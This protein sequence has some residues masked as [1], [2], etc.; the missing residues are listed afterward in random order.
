[1]RYFLLYLSTL[2]LLQ[3]GVSGTNIL[4]LGKSKSFMS[5][6]ILD[7]KRL[8]FSKLKEIKFAE[9]SDVA[10]DA[11]TQTLY[12]VSDKGLLYQ[13]NTHFSDKIDMLIP[14]SATKLKTKKGKRLKKWKRDS[15]GLTLDG[16]N[17]LLIS[18][19]G[20]A[21]ISWFHKNSAKVGRRIKNYPLPKLLT[22]EKNYRSRN[23]SLE[24]L[25]WHPRYGILTATE[26][27]LKKDDKKKQTI[28]A[29]SGK[30][31]HFKAEPEGRS[32]VSAIE[33]MDDGNILVLERSYTGLLEPF[34]VTLKKVYLSHCKNGMYQTKILAKMSNHKG[35]ELDNFEGLARVGKHRYVMVNDD[36]DNFFQRT[37]LIYFEVLDE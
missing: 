26:W 33:V 12:F 30:Q 19:E 1:M 32:G 29:L 10:Y 13:F 27:P 25:A 31:W 9:L 18:F 22:E 24:S 36:N 7:Q 3:A 4:P 21:K 16:H 5:I 17:R 6:K 11:N 28:Y 14:L 15:E 20:N 8:A 37:L 34:V 35:W 2:L 23:K